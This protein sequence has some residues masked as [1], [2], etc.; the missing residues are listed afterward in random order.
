MSTAIE[1]AIAEKKAVISAQGESL[2]EAIS[3]LVGKA[4][5]GAARAAVT[6]NQQNDYITQY[7]AGE[8][9]ASEYAADATADRADIPVGASITLN[10]GG[11]LFLRDG[12]GGSY[13]T[14]ETAGAKTVYNLCPGE[15]GH[16]INH[17][18]GAISQV[19]FLKPTGKVRMIYTNHGTNTVKTANCRD[20]GGWAADGGT[21][22]YGKIFRGCRFTGQTTSYASEHDRRAFVDLLGVRDEIDLRTTSQISG[23]NY[24]AFGDE[25]DYVNYPINDAD[26]YKITD[27][28]VRDAY[29]NAIKRVVTDLEFGRPVYLHCAAGADRTGTL[30]AI[31]EALCGVSIA[32]VRTEYGLTAF[33]CK[34]DGYSANANRTRDHAS[35]LNML[36]TLQG[37]ESTLRDGAIEWALSGGLSYE[38]INALRQN[39]IDGTPEIIIRPTTEYTITNTLSHVT[40]SNVSA[41]TEANAPYTATLTA[42]TD[43]NTSSVSVTM[44]GTDITS[45]AYTS[46]TGVI[47]IASVTGNLI[48]TATATEREVI[49]NILDDVGYAN[50]HRMNSS[51]EDVTSS[52]TGYCLPGYIPISYGDVIRFTGADIRIGSATSPTTYLCYY[53]YE[54]GE[55]V[56]TGTVIGLRTGD[57]GASHTIAGFFTTSVVDGVVT[58]KMVPG[59]YAISESNTGDNSEATHVRFSVYG[60]GADILM[61][62]NQEITE[63]QNES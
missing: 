42:D 51:G 57:N 52:A 36:S 21:L 9:T 7:L 44:G 47:S 15:D 33:S 13:E 2:D 20:L 43:Y 31:I 4:G 63:V 39:L 35:M 1:Q 56:K 22:H 17:V 19:G 48:I 32:D 24:S 18:N 50:N 54:N 37:N 34:A 6:Y 16:Y 59:E 53:K 45:T 23:K 46:S 27:S 61:T 38:E 10:A 30:C 41:V 58:I 60:D 11:S 12:L 25:V 29:I 3:A 55:Y 26:Q 14:M 28:T 5:N 8:L 62:K 40:T 49:V